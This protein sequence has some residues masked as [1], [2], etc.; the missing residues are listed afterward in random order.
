[1][2][3]L[4]TANKKFRQIDF[5]RLFRLCKGMGLVNR[6]RKM[7]IEYLRDSECKSACKR[8]L[9]LVVKEVYKDCQTHA[10]FS[11][12][13]AY[14]QPEL[15]RQLQQMIRDVFYDDYHYYGDRVG[16]RQVTL[17]VPEMT[18]LN[19]FNNFTGFGNEHVSLSFPNYI[20][21]N[22]R[23]YNRVDRRSQPRENFYHCALDCIAFKKHWD[24]SIVI[25][26]D[27]YQKALT[28]VQTTNRD[29]QELEKKAAEQGQQRQSEAQRLF[30]EA[31]VNLRNSNR[32]A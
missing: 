32:E 16:R 19:S 20:M 12:A 11:S 30:N 8:L 9:S 31:L 28:D 14:I 1:M 23:A 5:L 3:T 21:F 25:I 26:M 15:Q 18:L 7:P 13:S 4:D 6:K 22:Y 29:R 17:P 27:A 24:A 2:T 10:G